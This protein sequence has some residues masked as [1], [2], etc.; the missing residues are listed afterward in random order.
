MTRPADNAELDRV[1]IEQEKRQGEIML[2]KV[3]DL[4]GRFV[5][6]PSA[7]ARIAHTLWIVHAHLMDEW[8]TTPRIAFLSAEPA[9]GKTRALEITEL[10]VPMPVVAVNMSVSYLFRKIGSG[11]VPPTILYD[12]ID[13]IFGPKAKEHEEIR[14]LLNAG[15][16]RGA[17]AGRCVVKG[18]IVQTEEL[19]AYSAVALAGLGW[20]PDT[21]LSRSIIIRMRRRKADEKIEPFRRRL[22]APQG[23]RV[24]LLVEAWARQSHKIT[25]PDL[26]PEIQ[27]RDADSWEPLIAIA[28]LAGGEWPELA[29]TAAVALVAVSKDAE[30]S[31]G[32]RLLADLR[33]VFADHEQMA[34]KVILRALVDIEESPWGDLKGKAIDERGLARRLRQYGIKSRQIRVGDVTLKGYIRAELADAW[35]RYLSPSPD[36]SETSETS[37]TVP[38]LQG[39][40]VSDVSHSGPNVSDAVSHV[41]D[42]VSDSATEIVNNINN[43]S[44]VSL[45]SL[46]GG[47]GGRPTVD[48]REVLGNLRGLAHAR[49]I[50]AR[51]GHVRI[52][53]GP[54][55]DTPTPMPEHR[56]KIMQRLWPQLS[57]DDQKTLAE[58]ARENNIIPLSGNGH[59]ETFSPVCEHCGAPEQPGNPVQECAVGD[60]GLHLLHRQCQAEWIGTPEPAPPSREASS[61]ASDPWAIPDWLRR[62][63]T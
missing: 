13:T 45:V 26:P 32:I 63:P 56:R 60:G 9:S 20:L 7:A 27:D 53:S 10:L 50:T 2:R 17:V 4:L 62:A 58:W 33:T 29:R 57:P 40:D 21:I 8:E 48:D 23:A 51:M 14:A 52:D 36:K 55:P 19:P 46:P 35:L 1:A 49:R 42:A 18:N 6:Y 24:R 5:A 25:W 12:E 54:E 16:R 34:T 37:E 31:L 38:D 39:S 15:H 22:H 47:T 28:D 59:A 41:S 30:P 44:D 43:V 11:D 61:P 3:H